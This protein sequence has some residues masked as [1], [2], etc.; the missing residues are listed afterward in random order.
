VAEGDPLAGGW[1][2]T[3]VAGASELY[4]DSCISPAECVAIDFSGHAFLGTASP[5][6]SRA[7]AVGVL[8]S[9]SSTP[10]TKSSPH[11]P[12]ITGARLSHARFRVARAA[13]ALVAASPLG[14]SFLFTLSAGARVQIVI[15]R[16]VSGLRI[17]RRGCSAPTRA[18]VH[19]HAHS[20]TR[21]LAV[22]TLTRSHELAGRDHIVFSGRLGRRPLAAGS[23][24]AILTATNSQ[25]SSKPTALTFAVVR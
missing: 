14:T 23:Y 3:R 7:P 13:T 4:A 15:V 5:P 20:C 2:V 22:G 1:T 16:S 12:L 24:R 9:T 18:L 8:S 19:A 21:I 10:P 11:P 6:A 17:G 25:G